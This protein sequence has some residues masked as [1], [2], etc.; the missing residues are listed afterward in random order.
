M[1]LN[2]DFKY[3]IYYLPYHIPSRH[4]FTIIKMRRS[5][6]ILRSLKLEKKSFLKSFPTIIKS[7]METKKPECFYSSRPI[8]IST[9]IKIM[10][11][12]H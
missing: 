5:K 7:I 2:K 4:N 11:Y 12:F 1:N 6:K 8:K 10:N 3:K 9:K